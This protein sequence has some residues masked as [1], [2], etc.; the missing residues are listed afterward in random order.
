MNFGGNHP[1][2][3]IFHQLWTT[4]PSLRKIC[5]KRDPCLGPENPPIRAAHTRTLN[6]LCNPPGGVIEPQSLGKENLGKHFIF[7][8]DH[9]I[10]LSALVPMVSPVH[11]CSATFGQFTVFWE[12]SRNFGNFCNIEQLGLILA[13]LQEFQ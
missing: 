4:H 10:F 5:R 8:F 7:S 2:F 11:G 1:T 6:M 9:F 3:A 13:I 12:T